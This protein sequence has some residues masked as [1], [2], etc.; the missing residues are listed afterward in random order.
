M[1]DF[2]P[3]IHVSESDY[4]VF[5]QGGALCDEQG[6]LGPAHFEAALRAQLTL[7]AQRQLSGALVVGSTTRIE[8]VQL[9][10]LKTLLREQVHRLS[11]APYCL[12]TM[13]ALLNVLNPF[14][15]SYV[16][17]IRTDS[18]RLPPHIIPSHS[19]FRGLAAV[20]LQ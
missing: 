15:P 11:S 4:A 10:T 6:N 19:R 18:G 12:N 1:Q 3:P 7:Y 13:S 5:T 14:G 9:A 16:E 17:V 20:K 8:F 2:E